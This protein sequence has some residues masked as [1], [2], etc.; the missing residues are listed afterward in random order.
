MHNN[1]SHFS[2]K[3]LFGA[4]FL[5]F[6]FS[7]GLKAQDEL[8]SFGLNAKNDLTSFGLGLKDELQLIMATLFSKKKSIDDYTTYLVVGGC[9]LVG[10]YMLLK[11]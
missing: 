9:V 4:V 6:A 2:L 3:S 7:F 10:G 11:K 5:F 1:M 8:V